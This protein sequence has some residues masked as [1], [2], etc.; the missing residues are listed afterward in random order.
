MPGAGRARDGL[1]RRQPVATRS[2]ALRR[3]HRRCGNCTRYLEQFRET[4]RL[5]GTLRESDV[6]I[7][8]E[9]TLLAQFEAWRADSRN[10]APYASAYGRT[11]DHRHRRDRRLP[12]RR[13]VDARQPPDRHARGRRP[14]DLGR[15]ARPQGARLR[16][17]EPAL[18]ADR[19][20]RRRHRR[21][22]AAHPL[23]RRPGARGGRARPTSSS[24]S[25]TRRSASRRATRRS[26]RSSASRRSPSS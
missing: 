23:D 10:R 8:A 24:S 16:V 12:E 11:R 17:A 13:E 14:R 7:E 18:P 5:T 20:R 2:R 9:A 22:D 26:R 19:H 1:P 21:R 6:S 15:H 4:I 25:S 3:A